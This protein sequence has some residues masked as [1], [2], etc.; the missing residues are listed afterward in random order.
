MTPFLRR[1]IVAFATILSFL[2]P[3]ASSAQGVAAGSRPDVLVVGGTPA[4]VAAAVAA[5]RGGARVTLVS[6]AEDLGGVLSDAMM[7]QWDLN[8]APDGSPVQ[9]DGLFTEI[10]ARLGDSFTPRAAAATF[11]AMVASEPNISVRYDEAAAGVVVANSAGGK[12]VDA[13]DFRNARTGAASTVEAR[14]VV[15]ATDDGDVA[16]L[17]GAR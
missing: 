5:A 14:F 4:G 9:R 2:M 13:V 11:A 15:D 17:A 7:D 10:Y 16:A 8:L 1:P 3:G 12:R 6:A